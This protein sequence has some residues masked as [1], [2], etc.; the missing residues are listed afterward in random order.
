MKLQRVSAPGATAKW[1]T[2]NEAAGSARAAFTKE[3]V[4]R[5]DIKTEEFEFEP[6]KSGIVD[7]LNRVEKAR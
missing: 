6:T 7:L 5:A 2:S 3:G 4:P 1:V